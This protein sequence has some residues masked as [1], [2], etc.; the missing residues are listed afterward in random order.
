[1]N[2]PQ[3]LD[4]LFKGK[5]FRVPDYQR[6]YAWGTDQWEDFWEDLVNLAPD[7]S[8]YTGV[9]TIKEIASEEI[10]KDDKEHWL[11]EN[12]S[13]RMFHVVD[14]QQ[15]LTTFVI[16][17]QAF[18]E[19]IAQLPD[20]AGK[21]PEDIY[22]V[23]GLSLADVRDNYLYKEKPPDHLFRTY[24]FGYAEDNPSYDYL[25]YRILG[26]D[27]SGSV[28]GTFYTL[29]LKNAKIYFT[30]QLADLFNDTGLVGLQNVYR[31]LTKRFRFNEYVIRDEF[32]VFVAF[33]TMNNRG[34]TLS[35][36]E[37]LKNRLIY[38][39]TLYEDPPLNPDDRRNLREHIND[40]WKE[41]YHQLGRNSRKPL[42]D[43]DFLRAHWI[44]YYKYSRETGK[45]YIHFLLDEKFSPKHV[46]VRAGRDVLL[47]LP[48]EPEPDET[49]SDD[50]EEPV[51]EMEQPE[52]ARIRLPPKEIHDYVTSLKDSSEH[53]F[54]SYFPR[55]VSGMAEDEIQILEKLNRIGIGYFRPLVMSILKNAPDLSQR[56]FIFRSIERFIFLAFR[57]GGARSNYRSSEFYKA[58]RDL[59]RGETTLEAID[60]ALSERLSYLF[61]SDGAL[62]PT[63]FQA[64]LEKKFKNGSGYYGWAG[65]RYFLYEYELSLL[66][67]SRQKKVDWEDL[68]KSSRKKGRHDQISIEHICPQ[69]PTQYWKAAFGNQSIRRYERYSGS[70]GNLVLLSRS[71]NSSLQNDS[72]P[73]KKDPKLNDLGEVVRNGYSEGS[74]SEIEVSR[75]ESWGPKEV[76]ARG[77]KLLSFMETRWKVRFRDEGAKED[78]LFL[79]SDK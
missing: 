27:G 76:R 79:P 19:C 45:D 58:A 1:M 64:Q 16:F 46:Y 59:D 21:E 33:E 12:H 71:I 31:T 28:A 32:D 57:F 41:V 51:D 4:E 78:L 62:K 18:A 60:S 74:H 10:A 3:S 8:H 35:D 65:L 23:D 66:D 55:Q 43:D 37:L 63:S 22:F 53:W 68:L 17:L 72:F 29:N 54:A 42:N 7:R 26:E 69:T 44:T 13:Y 49:L 73:E 34:K 61:E 6:G 52:A 50:D 5:I 75:N 77:L 30:E 15:R 20:F 11:V 67:R 56:L 14:G 24:K 39:A 38:L 2:E 9:L 48:E 25:R 70:L 36:L 47:D 40:G